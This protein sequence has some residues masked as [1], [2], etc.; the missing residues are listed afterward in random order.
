MKFSS[1]EQ[2]INPN[3]ENFRQHFRE[4]KNKLGKANKDVDNINPESLGEKEMEAWDEYEK[5]AKRILVLDI[6][7]DEEKANALVDEAIEWSN[8]CVCVN[9]K[10]NSSLA[11]ASLVRNRLQGLVAKLG[12]WEVFPKEKR[13]DIMSDIREDCEMFLT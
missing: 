7:D 4:L 2:V 8:K 5:L 12:L 1:P 11:Y 6:N 10:D 13:V 3:L 9:Q